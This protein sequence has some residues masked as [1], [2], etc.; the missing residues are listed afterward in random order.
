MQQLDLPML[1]L[2]K[3][4]KWLDRE[5]VDGLKTYRQA[6]CKCWEMRH[7]YCLTKRA[8]AE[9]V[10]LYSSHLSDYLSADE[11]KSRELPAKHIA[12]F[13][14]ALGNHAITQWMHAQKGITALEEIQQQ[15]RAA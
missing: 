2:L 11:S 5:I 14:Y 1:A 4:P 3:E 15:R 8:L 10:G 6:V 12:A 13:E 9:E 7:R